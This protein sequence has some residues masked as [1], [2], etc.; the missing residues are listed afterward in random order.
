MKE[1]FLDYLHGMSR[2]KERER[3]KKR[4]SWNKTSKSLLDIRR[5]KRK[6]DAGEDTYTR[7]TLSG[8]KNR[9]SVRTH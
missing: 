7:E 3:K 8:Q 4:S 6:R 1:E 5:R 2:G 9:R